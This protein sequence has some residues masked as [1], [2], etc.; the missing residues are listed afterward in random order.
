MRVS[1]GG[2]D[3]PREKL[4]TPCPRIVANLRSALQEVAHVWIFDNDDLRTPFRLI[5]VYENGQSIQWR[6]PLPR[7]FKALRVKALRVLDK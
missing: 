6:E 3:V 7:W 4:A 5:A 1:Q 2:H